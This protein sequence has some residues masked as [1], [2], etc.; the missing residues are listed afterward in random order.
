MPTKKDRHLTL[1]L[2][3]FMKIWLLLFK[4][5]DRA[6]DVRGGANIGSIL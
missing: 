6:A 5:G 3:Q 1:A 4:A 2:K